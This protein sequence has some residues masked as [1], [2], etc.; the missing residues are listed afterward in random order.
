MDQANADKDIAQAKAEER[1]SMAIALE[2]EMRAQVTN[3]KSKLVEAEAEI[4]MSIAEAL[5]SGRL[6]IMDY[7]KMKNIMADTDM[8]HSI[9]GEDIGSKK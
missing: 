8:R 4:P 1:R 2:Q 9:A 3:M 5:A 6:P 7:Y